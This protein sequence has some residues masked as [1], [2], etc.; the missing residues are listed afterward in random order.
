MSQLKNVTAQKLIDRLAKLPPDSKI[1]IYDKE[2]LYPPQIEIKRVT[3]HSEG[4]AI[5]ESDDPD[6]RSK[7]SFE[8]IILH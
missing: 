6:L 8:A 4:M 5:E 3:Q 2:C 7:S 1:F